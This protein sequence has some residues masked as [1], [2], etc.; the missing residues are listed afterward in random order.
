MTASTRTFTAGR[1]VGLVLIGLALLALGYL[2]F[3]P[4][5]TVSV[6]S[7]AKAGDLTLEPCT[8]ATE[9]GGYAAD[10]GTLVVPEN[11]ADPQSRLIALPVTRIHA[12]SA[13]PKEPVFILQGGPGHTNMVFEPASRYAADRDVVL[14]GY[15]GV[16][17]SVKLDCPEVESALAHSTDVLGEKSFDAYANGFRDCAARLT[18]EGVDLAGYGITGQVEDMEAARKA[19]GYDRIDLLSESAGTRTA[20]IYSWRHPASI[21]RSVL[22]GVNPPGHF[23][24]DA[25]TTDDQIE[26]YAALCSKDPSCSD[27]T[28][29]LAA[30]MR[31]TKIPDRWLFLPIKDANVRIASFFGL[32]E[33]RP[34]SAAP[35]AGPQIL[36]SWLSAAGGDASAMWFTSIF[37]DLLLPKLFV[38]GQYAAFG[39][40]DQQAVRDYF[41]SAR[42]ADDDNLGQASSTYVWGDGRLRDAWPAQPDENEYTQVRTSNVETLLIGGALDF[43]TPP[44]VSTKELMPHLPNGH[45]VVLPWVGHTGSFF[46]EQPE[47]GTHLI[48]TFLDSGRVDDSRYTPGSVDFTPSVPLTT[49][50][51]AVAGSLVGLALVAL[52]SL[53]WMPLRVHRRGRFGRKTG[54]VLRSLYPV[55][56]GLGGWAA[57]FLIVTTTMPGVPL[58]DQLVAALSVGLPIGVGLHFAWV[59]RDWAA[60]TKTAGLVAAAV[61][62]LVGAWLGFH[63]G[64]GLFALLTAILGAAAAGNLALV[65][66]DIAWDRKARDRL[67]ETTVPEKL[68]ARPSTG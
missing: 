34:S 5:D 29:D 64:E 52:L 57:G 22:I 25:R 3:A 43:T 66:L 24:W 26:R 2:R 36:D 27:R 55:V 31:E 19:L 68:E 63:A 1:I 48:N 46:A 58:D 40:A 44:Q 33:S 45:E 49:I 15:R 7:G 4:D 39:R 61:G 38:W 51:K 56:L 6:P 18:D 23:L 14:V 28:D 65:G 30:T 17:G 16:D 11:R 53:L 41:A 37:G 47:A 10:C 67:A 9:D 12:R 8:Y 54:V 13:Q 21:H 42:P 50:A 35:I 32:M 60:G 59:N 62:A 20:L